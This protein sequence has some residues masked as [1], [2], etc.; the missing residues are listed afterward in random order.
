MLPTLCLLTV[1]LTTGQVGDRSAWPLQPQLARGQELLYSGTYIEEPLTP[2]VQYQKTLRL[3]T[4]LLVLDTTPD[5]TEVA[6]LTTVIS[7]NPGRPADTALSSVRLEVMFLDRQGKLLVPASAHLALPLDGPPTIELGALVE[8]PKSRVSVGSWWEINEEGRPPRTWRVDGAET[9]NNV[10]CVRLIGVQKSETWDTP[11]AD[12][13]AW[14]RRDT[15]WVSAELGMVC[16]FERELLRRDAAHT[17][18]T[19]RSVVRCDLGTALTYQGRLFDERADEI[20]QAR[21]FSQECESFLRE[22]EKNKPRLEGILKRIKQYNEA[23]APTPYRKAIVQVQKRIEGSLRGET[24]PD[25]KAGLIS[26]TVRKV[27]IGQKVPDFVCSDLITNGTQRL[28]RL[29]GKPIMV[30]F[31]NPATENGQRALALGLDLAKRYPDS[32]TILPLAVTED[33]EL[34]MK[35]HKDLKLPFTIL[36]GSGL[37]QLFGVDALPRVVVLDTQGVVRGSTTGWGYQIPREVEELLK[38]CMPR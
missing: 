27:A 32:V 14:Q 23:E 1:A 20:K 2:G 35:Q 9:V 28:E 12:S 13:S 10:R 38:K 25:P 15:V 17:E 3:E 21:R 24:I 33:P 22:P 26:Q 7:K 34:A 19:F 31:Y 5:K 18:P 37:T 16:R 29:L 8:V 4:S 11:R 36:D 6:V 30:L